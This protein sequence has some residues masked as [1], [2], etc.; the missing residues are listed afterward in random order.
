[1]AAASLGA[2]S[3]PVSATDS[4]AAPACIVIPLSAEVGDVH[5][6]HDRP[7]SPLT[8]VRSETIS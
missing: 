5:V 3:V 6:W 2:T 1:M 8:P 4:V 7:R